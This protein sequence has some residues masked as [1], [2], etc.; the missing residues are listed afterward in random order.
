MNRN[1]PPHPSDGGGLRRHEAILIAAALILFAV[2][3]AY[4]I[5][6]APPLSAPV[7]LYRDGSNADSVSASVSDGADP[8]APEPDAPGSEPA[9]AAGQTEPSA[10]EPAPQEPESSEAVR[11]NVN[12][13]DLAELMKLPGIGEVKARSI[14]DYREEH[15]DFL[16]PEDLLAVKGIGEKTLEKLR[17]YLAF[18]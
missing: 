8:S 2:L 14:L 11:V 15:G 6:S 17:P 16:R 13:A 18:E 10:D 7:V 9:P 5:L 3:I 1:D 12:T 4:N